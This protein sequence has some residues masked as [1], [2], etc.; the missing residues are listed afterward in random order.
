MIAREI[1]ESEVNGW[2]DY[3]GISASLKEK[4]N[5]SVEKM[6]DAVEAGTLV[7]NDDKTLLQ[8][9]VYPFG[10]ETKITELKYKPTLTVGEVNNHKASLDITN[11]QFSTF[12]YLGAS[13]GQP[14]S[15][16]FKMDIRDF[17]LCDNIV[18]FFIL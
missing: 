7:I 14:V 1:A 18:L 10:A 16:L 12:A 15:V 6:I 8:K 4:H 17:K 5:P 3:M 2:L 9:M 11:P 13:T